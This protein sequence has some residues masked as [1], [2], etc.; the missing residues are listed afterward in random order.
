MW[1]ALHKAFHLYIIGTRSYVAFCEANFGYFI[2]HSS[3]VTHRLVIC[4]SDVVIK[5]RKLQDHDV[6]VKYEYLWAKPTV[7]N[8]ADLSSEE[9]I[10]DDDTRFVRCYL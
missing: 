9:S 8:K 7:K 3:L 6:D 10:Q 1:T 4:K 2:H 5:S